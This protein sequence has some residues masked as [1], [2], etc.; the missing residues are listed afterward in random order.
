LN[1]ILNHEKRIVHVLAG[2]PRA[3]MQAGIPLS[4]A[5]CQV[6]AAQRY[7]LVIAAPGGH[8]KDINVYQ[9][10]K[11]LYH[12]CRVARPAAQ[13]LLAAAC[14]EGAGSRAYAAW[15]PG[16]TS[17]AEVLERFAR[18]GFRIGPHKAYQLARDSARV[19]LRLLSQMPPELA[20][21]LLFDPIDDWQAAVDRAE[22]ELPAGERIAILPRASATIPYI[23]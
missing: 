22:A 1:A 5:V 11:A 17:G 20:R 2:A 8:P 19:R 6:G 15:M 3:V 18:E 21:F 13:V 16:M 9:A 23:A 14:P 7:A 12:A 10:Q 4:R